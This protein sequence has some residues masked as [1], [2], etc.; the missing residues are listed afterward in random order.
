MEKGTHMIWGTGGNIVLE[1]V[2][3]DYY[4]NGLNL[5]RD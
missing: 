2:M 5:T 3:M 4:Q 1:E